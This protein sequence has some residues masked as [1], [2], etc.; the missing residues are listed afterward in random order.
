M[1]AKKEKHDGKWSTL[2][3]SDKKKEDYHCQNVDD[4]TRFGASACSWTAAIIL[5]Y[6][7]QLTISDDISTTSVTPSM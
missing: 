1:I 2:L 3:A 5:F 6:N 4:R 7:W